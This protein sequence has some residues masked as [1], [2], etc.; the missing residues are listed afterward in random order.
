[1]TRHGAVP[2][3]VARGA[4]AW[5]VA[6]VGVLPA[7]HALETQGAPRANPPTAT[8]TPD[9]TATRTPSAPA[10]A[11]P[12]PAAPAVL[13]GVVR[14]PDRKPL[15]K[16]LVIAKSQRLFDPWAS[17]LVARTDAQGRF[18]LVAPK[19]EPYT[20]RA[21]ADG[22]AARTVKDATPGTPLAI[23]LA[24]G[25]RIE[26]TVRD[27]DT[28]QPAAGA[29]VEV[30]DENFRDIPGEASAGRVIARTDANGRFVLEALPPGVHTVTARGAGAFGS[31]ANV[32]VG[33]RV[34]LTLFPAATVRGT[35]L[36]PDGQ[37]AAGATVQAV[38]SRH[39]M[40]ETTDGQGRFVLEGLAAGTYTL[41]AT[42]PR[43]AP[44]VAANVALDR[45]SEAQV[46]LRLGAGAR[47]TGRLVDGR[48]RPLAGRVAIGMLDGEQAPFVLASQL[49]AEP[50]VDGRFSIDMVPAGEHTLSTFA[51]G[52]GMKLVELTVRA[53]DRV[54]DVGDVLLEPG[55]VIRGR[56]RNSTG[57][58]IEDASLHAYSS[59]GVGMPA[60]SEA[61]GSFV[62][63]VL[64]Q[65]PHRVTVEAP[66]YARATQPAEPGA[67]P[68]EIVLERG[69]VLS[70]LVVD[71]RSRPLDTF[72][73]LARPVEERGWNRVPRSEEVTS[74]EGRFRLDRL[75]SGAFAVTVTAPEHAPTT[76][77]AVRVAAGAEVDLGTI[78]LAAGG[79]VRGSV[80]D[81][82]GAFVAG[83][84]VTVRAQNRERFAGSE[85]QGTTDSAGAF[86]IKGVAAGSAQV[87]AT[88][89]NFAASE[90]VFVEVDAKGASDVR[91]VLSQGGRVAGSVRRRDGAPLS[92][93]QVRV[94]PSRRGS[95]DTFAP[96][97]ADGTFS[98][99]HVPAGS[100]TVVAMPIGGRGLQMSAL[101][102]QVDVRD[103]ETTTVDIVIRDIL[104]SGRAT[105]SGTPAPGLRLQASGRGRSFNEFVGP[106]GPTAAGPQRLWAVT[107][108]DGSFEMLLE[109]PGSI[110]LSATAA[111]GRTRLPS[112][113][114]EVPDADAHSVEL[115]YSGVPVS[116]IVAEKDT[117]APVPF[118]DVYARPQP[119]PDKGGGGS[120]ATSGP[121]GRFQLE[122]DP[123]GYR[124][125]ARVREGGL[126]PVEITLDVGGS[127][128]SDVKLAVPK[129]LAIAG[130]V[131]DTSG[132]PVGGVMLMASSSEPNA[133]GWGESLADGTFSLGGLK[134]GS[135]TVTAST[136]AGQFGFL[137]TV[138]AG[139]KGATVV[140]RQGG[141]LDVTVVGPDGEPISGSWPSV[142][143]VDG[144]LIRGIGRT[145]RPTDAQGITTM[146]V[147][148]GQLVIAAQ[149]GGVGG[150]ASDVTVAPG[151]RA[152]VR[153]RLDERPAG[154]NE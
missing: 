34:D 143:R 100:A 82:S 41:V 134:A 151:D 106:P 87:I 66:G 18:R 102:R 126:G 78:K 12:T 5:A 139:T 114:I 38:G 37:P 152:S 146:S 21:E 60:R 108:E 135:F 1:V 130:R 79:V 50:G 51:P 4:F 17:P 104:L 25:G 150:G 138:E 16:A 58:P 61:D 110:T 91:L 133:G 23:D 118:A 124:I 140:V 77:P 11:R 26:G 116:G 71:D 154:G 2:T 98:V 43:R 67:D 94:N 142:T 147:P 70:G 29:R 128:V 93:M 113:T 54:V 112:R 65:A 39:P 31:K 132:R 19:R 84:S 47:V 86:E 125:G 120:G 136:Q 52:Q 131:T 53:T 129:G 117:D 13:E 127:G 137:P 32:R 95:A 49:S 59:R 3:A 75:A 36:D 90:A 30:R 24:R 28:G 7:T 85:P 8:R 62:L 103:G 73:V 89:P 115:N 45:R 83:A 44:G 97:L 144:V 107:R 46:E 145:L 74:E 119:R 55:L 9:A 6:L 121:D 92:A 80:V 20:V 69:A 111:D 109:E 141:T 76:V 15:E 64:E 148:A 57:Q 68:V 56:V 105:R 81:E 122:L 10:K 101:S 35:V 149:K 123:G 33:A 14:G 27:G 72:R 153:I 22:L 42:A 88:H 96:L 40:A 63:A 99:D 48:E